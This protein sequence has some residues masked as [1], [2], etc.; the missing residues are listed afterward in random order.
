MAIGFTSA[1]RT[2]DSMILKADAADPETKSGGLETEL[3]VHS[4]HD[5]E[6]HRVCF[7]ARWPL[8]KRRPASVVYDLVQ[9]FLTESFDFWFTD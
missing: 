4:I 1:P 6:E 9:K 7:A 3:G 2:K 8:T 5:T